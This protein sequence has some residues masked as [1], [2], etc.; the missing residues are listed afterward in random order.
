MSS[1]RLPA[2]EIE[3]IYSKL[4]T[5]PVTQIIVC[6][7]AISGLFLSII[8]DVSLN[9]AITV[10]SA[11]FFVIILVASLLSSLITTK[12]TKVPENKIFDLRRS[13]GLSMITNSLMIVLFPLL[14]AISFPFGLEWIDILLICLSAALALRLV[15]IYGLSNARKHLIA[16]TASSHSLFIFV[17]IL[18]IL[19]QGLY[20]L[21]KF[22]AALLI[23][24]LLLYDFI[25]SVSTKIGA[26]DSIS[27][28]RGFAIDWILNDPDPLERELK[29]I[30]E[31][32]D[33]NIATV[34]FR[35]LRSKNP[36]AFVIIPSIH[37]GPFRNVGSSN[38]PYILGST[39]EK[40]IKAPTLV[41]HGPCTHELDMVAHEEV[42]EL[43]NQ[44]LE[45]LN[46]EFIRKAPP[47]QLDVRNGFE[48]IVLR[49]N[50]IFLSLISQLNGDVEDISLDVNERLNLIH[51]G[52]PIMIVDLHNSVDKGGVPIYAD[53]PRADI[54]IRGILK[55]ISDF[56]ELTSQ[57]V[58]IGVS[59][60][61]NIAI[62]LSEGL[63]PDG[64][65]V[66]ILLIGQ[67]PLVLVLF[68]SNNLVRGL[69]EKIREEIR[70]FLRNRFKNPIVA[71]ATTDTH[72]TS[73]ITAD[74]GYNPLG[75]LTP[76][77]K[78]LKL[79]LECVKEALTNI[80]EVEFNSRLITLRVRVLGRNSELLKFMVK[81]SYEVMKNS[82]KYKVPSAIIL[83]MI[84]L[85]FL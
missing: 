79:T 17:A 42:E 51:K 45:K 64:I 41:F 59:K 5:L 24:G 1:L 21:V 65:S 36:K 76:H 19:G 46:G 73:A 57:R 71:V 35:S 85:A 77:K 61:R 30:A 37:P 20:V 22:L 6:L 49:L 16:L 29:K 3:A 7:T 23:F 27:L 26:T 28:F 69:G 78:I 58:M 74:V 47:P 32:K 62:S 82:L 81:R 72:S 4:F 48:I 12:L 68:D 13:L 54:L 31:E 55:I 83:S 9:L 67:R 33:I 39:L 34:F 25:R 38:L 44:L 60:R 53:D 80:E 70:I 84:L 15:V 14:W 66:I 11:I 2:R 40:K 43:A 10:H 50:Q 75:K 63:G 8:L 52:D 18:F 56:S